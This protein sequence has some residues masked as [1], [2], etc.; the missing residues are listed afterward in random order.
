MQYEYYHNSNVIMNEI[1]LDLVE[2]IFYKETA[3]KL[4]K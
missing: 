3:I 2:D 4:E 1:A